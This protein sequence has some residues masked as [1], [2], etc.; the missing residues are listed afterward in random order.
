MCKCVRLHSA[1]ALSSICSQ[2][3]AYIGVSLALL[4]RKFLCV[5]FFLLSHEI[6]STAQESAASSPTCVSLLDALCYNFVKCS[7]LV[8]IEM[9]LRE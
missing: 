5:L 9:K 4:N 3:C 8:R 6:V 7:S 2:R 1:S